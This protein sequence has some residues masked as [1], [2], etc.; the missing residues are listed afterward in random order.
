MFFFNRKK[1]STRSAVDKPGAVPAQLSL[2]KLAARTV[3]VEAAVLASQHPE[4]FSRWQEGRLRP[5]AITLAFDPRAQGGRGV[6][7]RSTQFVGPWVDEACGAHEPAVDRWEKGLL[8]PTWEQLCKLSALTQTPLET[9]L[10]AA[11]G[12]NLL[13]GCATDPLGFALRQ[14]FHPAIV[15]T[16]VKAHPEQTSL[17]DMAEAIK[18]AISIAQEQI[19]AGTDPY[20]VFIQS[21]L[22]DDTAD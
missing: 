3:G 12:P 14:N 15:A 4:L 10:A 22:G 13:G 9:L 19:T 6:L 7:F 17:E 5:S 20:S 18:N 21:L 11:E 8:Y 16:T 1:P 2:A